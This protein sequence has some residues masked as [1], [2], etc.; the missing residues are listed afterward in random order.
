[1]EA[2]GQGDQE[3]IAELQRMDRSPVTYVNS[4]TL[5]RRIGVLTKDAAIRW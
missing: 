4:K 2:A 3:I 5:R 1:M